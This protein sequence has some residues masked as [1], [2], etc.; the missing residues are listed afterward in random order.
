MRDRNSSR[1][2]CGCGSKRST[3]CGYC[4]KKEYG[5]SKNIGKVAAA[6]AV[7]GARD[8]AIGAISSKL[9]GAKYVARYYGTIQE[10]GTTRYYRN[11]AT[12]FRKKAVQVRVKRQVRAGVYAWVTQQ[13]WQ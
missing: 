10:I 12:A 8:L 11:I 2:W 9:A 4:S 7:S 1:V 13:V 6:G 5:K 3:I